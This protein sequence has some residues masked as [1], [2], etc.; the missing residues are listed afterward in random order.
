MN[1]YLQ[2]VLAG[3]LTSITSFSALAW[4]GQGH[5]MVAAIGQTRLTPEARDQVEQLLALEGKQSLSEIA[6]W[7][8]YLRSSDPE[9]GRRS[10]SWHYVNIAED[11]CRYDAPRHC[12]GDDCVVEQISRQGALLA[13]TGLPAEQRLQALKFVVH[14]VGDIHQPMH[15]GKGA[16]KGGN[17]HQ[18]NLDGHG[19]NLHSLWDSGMIESTGRD[20]ASYLAHLLQLPAPALLPG[21]PV[22]WAENSCRLALADGIY[23]PRGN[24]A[25]DYIGKQMPLIDTQMRSGG[26]QLGRLL[27]QLLGQQD[28]AAPR[29]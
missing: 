14:F 16:D 3:L 29:P 13:D 15:A 4:G 20:D 21:N 17:D 2:P 1:R 11:G 12:K 22:L 6:S 18:L 7:A 9:L 24:L 27:N 28:S 23:P 25:A 26:E 8:D 10:A 19:T 5:R